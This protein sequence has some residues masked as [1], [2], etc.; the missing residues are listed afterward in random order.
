VTAV[1]EHARAGF[2][3]GLFLDPEDGSDIFL[4]YVGLLSADFMDYI[5]QNSSSTFTCFTHLHLL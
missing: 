2:L 1:D 4:Q 3:L 5:P